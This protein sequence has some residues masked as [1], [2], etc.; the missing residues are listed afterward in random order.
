VADVKK[1]GIVTKKTYNLEFPNIPEYLKKHFV[2]GFF[3]GDG[4]ISVSNK[5][6]KFGFC[7]TYEMMK[8]INEFF[9]KENIKICKQKTIYT[10]VYGGTRQVP[11]LLHIIYDDA[12]IYL[13]RKYNL[14]KK[15]ILDAEEKN[16][17]YIKN[18]KNIFNRED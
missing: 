14:Y 15:Y 3:D 10:I 17:S 5:D 8:S 11:Q 9:D 18:I 7:G 4:W 13:D 6:I 16:I 2:R 1:H 12:T